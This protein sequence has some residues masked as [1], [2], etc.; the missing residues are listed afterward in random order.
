MYALRIGGG[1]IAEASHGWNI[2]SAKLRVERGIGV[3][4]SS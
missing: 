1:G 3:V 4:A 2:S